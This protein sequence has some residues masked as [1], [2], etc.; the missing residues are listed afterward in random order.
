[1]RDEF[2][3]LDWESTIH[4]TAT[5][6]K[7]IPSIFNWLNCSWN[8]KYAANN[9]KTTDNRCAISVFKIPALC[10]D[11]ARHKKILGNTTPKPIINHHGVFEIEIWAKSGLNQI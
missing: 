7:P 11:L 10:N 6:P 1:M 9:D 3:G 8:K 5:I 4:K 2:D